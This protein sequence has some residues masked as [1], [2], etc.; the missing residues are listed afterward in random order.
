MNLGAAVQ[1]SRRRSFDELYAENLAAATRFAYLLTGDRDL[2][3][4]V[5]QDAFVRLLGRYAELRNP[6]AFPAYLRRT[7]VNLVKNQWRRRDVERSF[8]RREA[9]LRRPGLDDPRERDLDDELWLALLALPHRQR[10]AIVL[11]YYEDQSEEATAA[12]LRCTVGAAKK[13]VSRGL[14]TLRETIPDPRR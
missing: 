14:E 2:A 13:L 6:D 8:L 1:G 10:A 9:A 3:D 5:V 7:I 11:R 4:E 12:C